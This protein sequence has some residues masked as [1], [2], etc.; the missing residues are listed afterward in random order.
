M[1]HK[2]KSHFTVAFTQSTQSLKNHRVGHWAFKYASPGPS[3]GI[4]RPVLRLLVPL[5]FLT[6]KAEPESKDFKV[7]K[8]EIASHGSRGLKSSYSS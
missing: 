4:V 1:L 6:A 5:L 8:L 7:V 2:T 3:N